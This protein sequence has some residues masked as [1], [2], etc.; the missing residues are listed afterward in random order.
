MTKVI[1]L[2]PFI[3]GRFLEPQ[4]IEMFNINYDTNLHGLYL[5]VDIE[6]GGVYINR[7]PYGKADDDWQ[8]I[9]QLDKEMLLANVN[10]PYNKPDTGD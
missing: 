8:K 2:E 7:K 10:I 4:S 6:T 3:N 9:G 1:V 5:L